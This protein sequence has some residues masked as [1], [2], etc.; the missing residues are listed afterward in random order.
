MNTYL[1]IDIGGTKCAV[2]LGRMNESDMC[3]VDKESVPTEAQRGVAHTLSRIH[4]CI[5]TLLNR[6]QMKAVDLMGMGISC[7]GPLDSRQ[8]LILSPPNLMGWDRIPIVKIM[9]DRYHVPVRLE[10]DANACALA[11]WRFGAG[12]GFDNVIFLTFGTGLGAGL[13]LNGRLY[14]GSSDMAGE[15]GH[16]RLSDHG[17]VGY[18]KSGSFEGF[19][20]GGGIAQLAQIKVL[21][22]LQMGESVAFCPRLEDIPALTAKS[23]SEAAR[24][25]DPLAKAIYEICGEYLGKGL[26]FLIDMLNPDRIIIG[27]VFTRSHDLLWPAAKKVIERETLALSRQACCVVTAQL[28]ENLGDYAALAVAMEEA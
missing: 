4:Q 14:R 8:G 27:S 21:E 23:V 13:I 3:I 26:S 28:Q 7:G 25:G 1:G 5:E 19:C 17:P 20:S 10:N 15:V 11:E 6:N 16:V 18:G 22:K 12:Q 24:Q 2:T 9:A